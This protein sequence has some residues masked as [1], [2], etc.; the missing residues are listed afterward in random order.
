MRFQPG[1]Q[2]VGGRKKGKRNKFSL[3]RLDEILAAWGTEPAEELRKL[4]PKL[5]A[6]QQA[7]I[8]LRLAEMRERKTRKDEGDLPLPPNS[9]GQGQSPINRNPALKD[10]SADQLISLLPVTH[11][12]GNGHAPRSS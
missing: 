1:H 7:Q 10:M 12:N 3:R 8:W 9:Q 5:S 2:K 6:S 4:M 11:V